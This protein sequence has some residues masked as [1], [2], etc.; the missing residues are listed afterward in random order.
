ME[1]QN[2]LKN[3]ERVVKEAQA[4]FRRLR[5][6]PGQERMIVFGKHVHDF[7]EGAERIFERIEK[8]T[9]VPLPV[10]ESWHTFLL[11]QMEH[12]VQKQ[13]PAVID[14]ALA[15]RLHR[16]LRFRHLFRHT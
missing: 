8:W 3:L 2:E 4:S 12:E 14:H 10:G 16:Y 15:L 6:P 7:Y 11:Q 13:R 1:V 5:K 9:E